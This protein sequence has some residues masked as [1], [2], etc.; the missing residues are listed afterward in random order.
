MKNV[1]KAQKQ[2]FKRD[3]EKVKVQLMELAKKLPEVKVQKEEKRFMS[4][5]EYL[6]LWRESH[7]GGYP[8]VRNNRGQVE[9]FNL[10]DR[11]CVTVMIEAPRDWYRELCKEFELG[12]WNRVDG[13]VKRQRLR[14]IDNL[15]SSPRNK[16][17]NSD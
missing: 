14:I 6:A 13:F 11:Y 2:K 17:I 1:T 10:N 7:P 8:T 16:E 5:A 9:A 4:G 12:G 15:L 3:L